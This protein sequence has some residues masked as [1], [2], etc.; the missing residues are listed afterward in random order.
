MVKIIAKKKKWGKWAVLDRTD[1]I[2]TIL[3]L[4]YPTVVE[5]KL[6]KPMTIADACASV[7]MTYMTLRNWLKADPV[8]AARFNEIQE[9]RRELMQSYAEDKIEDALTWKLKLRPA[10]QVNTA[11]RLLE[12]THKK[13]QPKQELEVKSINMDF[14]MSQE[15]LMNRIQ[16]LS[17]NM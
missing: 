11:F 17:R 1:K 3:T 9:Y 16:E 15:E 10:D 6:K 12:K 14:T 13:Y 4:T 7:D 2:N 8:L 5:G